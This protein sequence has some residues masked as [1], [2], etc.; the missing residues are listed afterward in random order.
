MKKIAKTVPLFFKPLLWS[1][2]FSKIHPK[3]HKKILIIQSINYGDLNHWRWLVKQYGKK[4]VARALKKIPRTEF[5]PQAWRLAS[6]MFALTGSN[7][8]SRNPP[9]KG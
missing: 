2:D 3:T 6:L 5:M 1:Y 9:R 8:A 4:S 7:N